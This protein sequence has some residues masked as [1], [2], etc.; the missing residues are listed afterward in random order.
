MM[1]NTLC[2]CYQAR[3]RCLAEDLA[4]KALPGQLCSK[5]CI[6]RYDVGTAD[7]ATAHVPR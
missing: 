1:I 3:T 7:A 5:A 2:C 6:S 4:K